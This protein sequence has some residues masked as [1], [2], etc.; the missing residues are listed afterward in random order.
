MTVLHELGRSFLG[1]DGE[2]I[3]RTFERQMRDRGPCLA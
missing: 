3:R 2:W 1:S